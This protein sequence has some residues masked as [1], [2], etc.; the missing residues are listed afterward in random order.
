[1]SSA[2]ED[3]KRKSARIANAPEVKRQQME[4]KQTPRQKWIAEN[5]EYLADKYDEIYQHMVQKYGAD[6][7]KKEKLG[8]DGESR[9]LTNFC[10]GLCEELC[11]GVVR[12]LND[13]STDDEDDVVGLGSED[14]EDPEAPIEDETPEGSQ[15]IYDELDDEQDESSSVD[16]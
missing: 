5:E 13:D 6:G 14:E 11:I 10:E 3:N 8:K 2:V 7:V 16:K 4:K 12:I 1:M 9:A 15:D